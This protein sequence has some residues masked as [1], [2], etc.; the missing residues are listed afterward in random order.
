MRLILLP[1]A[2]LDLDEIREPLLGR[3]VQRIEALKSF[4]ELGGRMP[5]PYTDF[6]GTVVDFFRIV[7]RV[8]ENGVLEVAFIRDCRRRLSKRP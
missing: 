3:V 8:R 6:R 1:R 2:L 7:Y 4:P 5:A